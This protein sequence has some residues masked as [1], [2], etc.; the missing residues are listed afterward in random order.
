[1]STQVTGGHPELVAARPQPGRELATTSGVTAEALAAT[2]QTDRAE[3]EGRIQRL[4]R[5]ILHSTKMGMGGLTP[6]GTPLTGR[7]LHSGEELSASSSSPPLGYHQV[8]M[9][10]RGAYTEWVFK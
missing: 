9:E 2:W 5:I 7:Q 3:L 8:C 6:M 4:K 10:I 1:V